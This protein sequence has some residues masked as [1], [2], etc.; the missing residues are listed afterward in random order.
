MK[1]R[2]GYVVCIVKNYQLQTSNI[3]I[4]IDIVQCSHHSV[5]EVEINLQTFLSEISSWQF[6][7]KKVWI[8]MWKLIYWR[9]AFSSLMQFMYKNGRK[10]GFR[11]TKLQS[12]VHQL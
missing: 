9:I 8:L 11:R 7:L 6:H 12:Q 3:N 1:Q 2:K 4:G 10:T 5:H